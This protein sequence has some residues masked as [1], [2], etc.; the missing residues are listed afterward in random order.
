MKEKRENV[1]CHVVRKD[2]EQKETVL[3]SLDHIGPRT[4]YNP[5]NMKMTQPEGRL[6]IPENSQLDCISPWTITVLPYCLARLVLI[7]SFNV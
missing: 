4:T 3:I 1:E 7:F 5:M 2:L 6:Q